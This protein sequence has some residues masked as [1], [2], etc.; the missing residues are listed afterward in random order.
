MGDL[1]KPAK[2][3]RQRGL[4]TRAYFWRYCR[5][6]SIDKDAVQNTRVNIYDWQRE[7]LRCSTE[8]RYPSNT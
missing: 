5:A 2:R 3:P 4:N 7:R 1:R 6:E 8:Q